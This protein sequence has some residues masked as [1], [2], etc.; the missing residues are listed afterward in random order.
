MKLPFG[1]LLNR[2][3]FPFLLKHMEAS[4]A[5][6]LLLPEL[7]EALATQDTTLISDCTKR[8]SRQEGVADDVKNELRDTLPHNLFL[9]VDR[10]DLLQL[11]AEI[12][13]IA[14]SAEDVAVLLSLRAY[15]YPESLRVLVEALVAAV[16]ETVEQAE[17]C[18]LHLE[19]LSMSGLSR[20]AVKDA[21]VDIQRIGEIEHEADKRQDQAA[22]Q[23]F[24][25]E[26]ELGAIGV[27]MWSK[28]LK[29]LGDVANHAE[30]VGDR[31]RLFLAR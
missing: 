8:V 11:I 4:K 26:D 29:K 1:R 23:L 6:A 17:K 21:L 16:N 25:L 31:M 24:L 5:C 30:N 15:A 27:M 19:T 28:V 2:S 12:D 9:S 20:R 3:P 13:R 22:K 14:D 7:F 18:L 10:R